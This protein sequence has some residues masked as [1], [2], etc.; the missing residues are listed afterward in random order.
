MNDT[1]SRPEADEV[2]QNRPSVPGLIAAAAWAIGLAVGLGALIAG[3][4]VLGAVAAVM[5][6][7]APWLGLGWIEHTHHRVDDAELASESR[8]AVGPAFPRSSWI[9]RGI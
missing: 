6:L 2:T 8:S 5:G 7:L 3:H 1:L 9:A 4:P